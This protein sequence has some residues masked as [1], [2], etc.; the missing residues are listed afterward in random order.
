MIVII[1][2]KGIKLN[3][4]SIVTSNLQY[5]TSEENDGKQGKD[6]VR[7]S[8]RDRKHEMQHY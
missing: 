6:S 2:Q 1:K 8:K 4:R 5:S 3:Y 7:R